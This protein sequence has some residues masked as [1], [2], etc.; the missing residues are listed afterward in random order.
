MQNHNRL[1]QNATNGSPQVESEGP[2]HLTSSQAAALRRL[3]DL[4]SLQGIGEKAGI[5][6]RNKPLLIGPSGSGKS[7]IARRLAM[8]EG[9][10]LLTINAGTW[11]VY[12]AYTTPHT[13]TVIRRFIRDHPQ[14]ILLID[15]IDKI[16]PAAGAYSHHWSLSVFS[17]ALGILDCDQKLAVSGWKDSD[18]QRLKSSCFVIGAGAWQLQAAA[19]RAEGNTGY[20]DQVIENAGIPE[21]VLFR[22]NARLVEI[23]PPTAKDFRSGI[24]R[25]RNEMSLPALPQGDEETL[26]NDAV[27]SN[28][29]MRWLEQYTADL[30]ITNGPDREEQR[31]T[32]EAPEFKKGK[33]QIT[34]AAYHEKLTAAMEIIST[35]MRTTFEA[36]VKVRLAQ[37]ITTQTAAE[38]KKFLPPEEFNPLVAA[39]EA[40][41]PALTIGT[42]ISDAERFRRETELHVHGHHLLAILDPWLSDRPFALKTFGLLDLLITIHVSIRRVH[43]YW[44]YLSSVEVTDEVG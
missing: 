18:I 17:E 20:A 14:S 9:L 43:A 37:A 10:P 16:V 39:L 5:A 33:L 34:K 12:G 2:R 44:K 30:L 22:F 26:I 19:A 15:E 13:L 28:R 40:F 1:L 42:S 25:L 21:E 11:I 4:A 29:G 41:A 23:R 6:V 36:T 3:S 8:L 35:L 27:E 31:P 38:D 24:R 32:E 7:A